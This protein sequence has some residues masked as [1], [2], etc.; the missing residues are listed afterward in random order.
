MRFPPFDD[1]EPP[2]DYSDN[3]LNAE[4]PETIQLDLDPEDDEHDEPIVDWFYDANP[5]SIHLMPMA[6]RRSTGH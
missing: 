4:L 1:E 3:V 6:R 5:S 2:F